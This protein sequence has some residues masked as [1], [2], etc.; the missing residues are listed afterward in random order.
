MTAPILLLAACDGGSSAPPDRGGQD[1]DAAAATVTSAGGTASPAL[2]PAT[3]PSVE[4]P[5]PAPGIAGRPR[6]EFPRIAHD[7]G[8][9]WDVGRYETRFEFVNRGDRELRI[10]EVKAGCGCTTTTLQKRVYAPGEA[11]EIGLVFSPQGTG[12]QTKKVTVVTD[13][14][15][16][17]LT[18]LSIS[19][20][21]REFITPV[22]RIVRF[23]TVPLGGHAVRRVLLTSHDP[24]A[25]VLRVVP[26]G[27]HPG[28]VT[29][30][31]LPDE[32]SDGR[33]TGIGTV[34][35][36]V[37]E[38]NPWGAVYSSVEVHSTG[39][40]PEGESIEHVARITCAASVYG[41]VHASDNMVRV[42]VVP[43]RGSFEKTVRFF[44]P[45]GRPFAL[46]A[47]EVIET[48][49]PMVVEVLPVTVPGTFGYDVTVRGSVGSY[50]GLI[51][52]M[53]V[54]QTDVPGEETLRMTVQGLVRDLA[55]PAGA[56]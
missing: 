8:D 51:R 45:D 21:I 9:I 11:G 29:A 54:V 26:A 12:R 41:S 46:T 30:R 16:H 44:S 37:H 17:Q 6:I 47:A 5:R 27:L 20:N 36:V 31:F 32:K 50:M 33:L 25:K 55:P 3:P 22:P 43:P 34:E 2:P 48:T 39:L 1:P 14:P 28:G 24:D 23:E 38:R 35:I 7:Y 53:L 15:L 4:P 42:E 56:H 49:V 19:A 52:G 40:T 13:D 18:E 10:L